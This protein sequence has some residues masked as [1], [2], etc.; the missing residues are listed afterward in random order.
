VTLEALN[1]TPV[2]ENSKDRQLTLSRLLVSSG[3][4]AA[5]GLD[6][7]PLSATEYCLY[8]GLTMPGHLSWHCGGH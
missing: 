7:L 6:S 8:L 5:S 3:F 1:L 2:P 4:P